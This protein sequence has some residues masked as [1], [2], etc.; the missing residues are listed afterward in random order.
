[1]FKNYKLKILPLSIVLS[2]F[3]SVNVSADDTATA[4]KKTTTQDV[5]ALTCTDEELG[6]YLNKEGIVDR[7]KLNN[8][9]REEFRRA[10][11][12]AKLEEAK[13]NGDV[14]ECLAAFGDNFMNDL[15]K[16][17]QSIYDGVDDLNALLKGGFDTTGLFDGIW[18]KIKDKLSE[19]L[20]NAKNSVKD[21]ARESLEKSKKEAKNKYN[22]KLQDEGLDIFTEQRLMD[23][24]LTDITRKELKDKMG[25]L[26]W[27]D[28]RIDEEYFKEKMQNNKKSKTEEAWNKEI[29][30]MF[31]D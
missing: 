12:S 29:N 7:V 11:L 8:L 22:K 28:G 21:S 14:Q 31:G 3:F 1:M 20:C 2:L 18:D 13:Q 19:E 16:L 17:K 5:S 27:K 26:K 15:A 10:Y 6:F 4:L 30:N 9:S 25:L 23:E 24:F